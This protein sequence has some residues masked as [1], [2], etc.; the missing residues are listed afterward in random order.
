M[1][2]QTPI[3]KYGL[4]IEKIVIEFLENGN[5]FKIIEKFNEDNKFDIVIKDKTN[6]YKVEIKADR[7][8]FKTNNFY[9]EYISHDIPSGINTTQADIL[10][11]VV[12]YP[13]KYIMYWINI[14]NLKEYINKNFNKIK[15]GKLKSIDVNNKING[16]YNY[17]YLLQISN[18]IDF[19]S[20]QILKS[21]L[22]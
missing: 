10:I 13:D 8:A 11:Y 3:F 9:I 16:K 22:L 20:E 19:K 18:N 14:N 15:I 7:Q 1:I 21:S 5:E 17:G 4:S 6:T 2:T 12:E